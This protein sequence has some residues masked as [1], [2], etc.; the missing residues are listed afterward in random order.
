MS[1][2]LLILFVSAL[3]FWS[4]SFIGTAAGLPADSLR[5]ARLFETLACVQCHSVNGK[6]GTTAPDLG[7]LINRDFNPAGLAATM[8]NH[9]PTMWA[10]MRARGLGAGDLDE[11]AA[12]DLFAYFYSARFFERPGDAGRGK[13]LFSSKRCAECHGLTA[14]K[15]PEIKPVTQWDAA[16]QPMALASAMWSHAATMRQEFTRRK[17][18]WPE[19]TTQDLADMLVYLRN[20]PAGRGG[21]VR[22]EITA[23]ASGE[24]LFQSKGCGGCHAGRLALA[25]RLKGRTLADIAVQM[26]NHASHM[27]P[28][29][30]PLTPEEM[31]ELTSYLW[32]EEFFTDSGSVSTGGRVFKNKSCATCHS[33]GAS[34]APRLP[35]PGGAF[36]SATMISVLWRHAP[37]MQEQ[38]KVRG[39]PW[40]RFKGR[41]MAD[42]IAYLNS[43]DRRHR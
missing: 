13:R 22:L 7:R 35:R 27:A 17:L 42:L 16:G 14:A 43:G 30:A 34:G 26:W 15:V 12:A 33:D 37:H 20:L 8:W 23:G 24:A 41:E 28:D 38:M 9:A 21:V 3:A 6:G 25:P 29:P 10:A 5:G 32:A 40:P 36:T 31:R 2:K 11:Q 4:V 19:L 39:V 18:S 1:R